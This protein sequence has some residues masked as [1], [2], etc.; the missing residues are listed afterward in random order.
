M[1]V[2]RISDAEFEVM[3][4]LWDQSPLTA[5]EISERVPADRKWSLQTVK[6][7]LSRLV[8]KGAI[9]HEVDGRRYLYRPLLERQDYVA[10]ESSRFVDRL[11]SG[12]AG[13][14]FAHLAEREAF[15]EEDIAEIERLLKEMKK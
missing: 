11:F 10:G 14:L 2:E 1:A 6:T 7:L 12:R 5:S 9:T 13:P 8:N 3:D 4:C 15:S